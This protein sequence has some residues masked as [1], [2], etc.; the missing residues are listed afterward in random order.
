MK[1]IK[2]SSKGEI[3][4]R[5]FSLVGATSKRNDNSKIGMFGSGLKYTLSYLLNNQIDF[6]VFSGY[7]EV[8]ITTKE[9]DFRGMSIKRIF[10]NGES[11]SLTTD[12]GMEWQRWFAIR[13]I[14]CNALDE[15]EASINIVEFESINDAHPVEDTTTFYIKVDDEFQEI[16]N[17]WDMYFSENRKD[18]IYHDNN[19][20]Q[21][22]V[23]GTNT[24]IY[25]KGIRCKFTE[26]KSLFHYDLSWVKINESRVIADDWD[27]NRGLCKFLKEVNNDDIIHRIVYNINNYFEKNL[28]WDISAGSFSDSW[29]NVI[30]E[31]TLVPYENAGFWEEEIK[32]LKSECIILPQS[33]VNSLKI[34]F[35][36]KIKVIGEGI[37][38]NRGDMKLVEKLG[39]R[40]QYLLDESVKFLAESKYEIKYPIK[41]VKFN[42]PEI[43]G[44]AKDDTIY[45]SE[46]LFTRGIRDIVTTIFEENEHNST[47]YSDE[48]RQ[49]QNHLINMVISSFEEKLGKYI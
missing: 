13:E 43:L 17:N 10:I 18:L 5:A 29:K 49:F 45:L 44:L 21:I 16:L 27:F 41:V 2:I 31:K 40:E 4:I 32:F 26:S 6:R 33:L 20:N 37:L 39:K 47:G 34:F 8:I 30:G 48:T 35:G 19:F 25:R 9:E 1:F 15:G 3:D 38:G 14:Y 23:G 22:Y 46:I 12:M 24:L 7:R 42:K 11:T 36:D 28:Y